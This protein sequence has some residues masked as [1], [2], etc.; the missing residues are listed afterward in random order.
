MV[1]R[2]VASMAAVG[3]LVIGA[4]V[5]A[6]P[7]SA[8]PPTDPWQ[9]TASADI[10]ELNVAALTFDF[11]G[12][13]V[14]ASDV[15]AGSTLDPRA[16]SASSN[17]G[18]AVLGVPIAVSTND[19]TAPP[20]EGPLT[21]GLAEVDVPT[22][23][24]TGLITT[25]N[26][27]S[28]TVDTAC[29]T[30]GVLASAATSV[31]GIS[32]LPGLAGGIASIG[33]AEVTSQTSLVP[34][35]IPNYNVQSTAVGTVAG[36]SLLGG[37]VE[38]AVAGNT[39]LTATSTAT[40]DI[41]IGYDP[42]TVTVSALGTDV[43]LTPA[44]PSRTVSIGLPLVGT[45]SVTVGL[46]S[47]TPIPGGAAVSLLTISI[48]IVSLVSLPV[49]TV[50]LDLVPL[51]ASVSAPLGGIDCPPPP[52]TVTAP[53]EG[54][55]TGPAPTFAG[56]ALP[57]ATVEVFVDGASIGTTTAD[58]AG[59][60]TLAAPTPLA[61]GPHVVTA[62]Q[63]VAGQV[64]EPSVA[65]DFVVDATPPPAPAISAPTDGA[66]LDDATPDI[67][68]TAEA[69]STVTVTIDGVVAGTAT[70]DAA[71]TWTFTPS[72]P[73]TD[74][75]HT[76]TATATDAAG[77]E[78][79][80]SNAVDFTI[81]SVAPEA[82]V[83]TSPA[84]GAVTNDTTPDITGTAEPNSTVTVTIDGVVA[85]TATADAAGTWTF[86]P[87]TPLTEGPHTVTA[88]ATDAAGNVSDASAPVTF[89]VDATPP[90]APVIVTPAEGQVTTDTTPDITG[91]AEPD[92]TIT[93]T[94]DGAIAGTTAADGTGNWVFTPTTPLAEGPHTVSATATDAAGNESPTS[95]LVNFTIDSVAPE[96]PVITSPANG[97]VTN[98]TTPDITGTA[99]PNST[100]T[101]TIDGVVAGTATADAAGTWTFTPTT[102]LTEGPHTVTA[103]ATDAAGN[104]SDASAPVE[105]TVDTVA[106]GTPVITGPTDGALLTDTTPDITGTAEP[107]STVTVTIDG[108]VAGTT[109]ADAAGSWTFTPS[110]PLGEGPHTVTAT[111]TDAAGNESPQSSAV[112][113]TID[114]VPP[115]APVI[116]GP[117][118]GD[119]LTD[120]T[121][122]ITGTAEPNSTVTVTIDGVVVG[123]TTADATGTW[124]FTPS[125]P[126]TEGPHTVTATAT[127]A[128]GNEGP[129]SAPVEFTVDTVPPAAPVITSP[130]D[131]STTADQAPEIS[132]IAE[133]GSTVTVIIDGEAAGQ[134]TADANG[135]WTFTPTQP[136]A[137]GEHEITAT[138]T[139][140]AGNTSPE[141][142]PTVVTVEAAPI[143]GVPE[144]RITMSPATQT[145]APGSRVEFTV[146][147][148]NAGD[149]AATNIVTRL[150]T[151]TGFTGYSGTAIAWPTGTP[152]PPDGVVGSLTFTLAELAP[153]DTVV[154]E[155]TGTANG[156]PGTALTITGAV[157][158]AEIDPL[159]A[160][161]IA[162]T[163]IA[164]AST[165][166]LPVTGGG[167]PAAALVPA[168]M[169][170]ALGVSLMVLG[171]RRAAAAHRR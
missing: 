148:R 1:R 113:F 94:I 76:V 48:D 10:V 144:V 105:F 107:S 19:A 21:G 37:A 130:T 43:V 171:R 8:A 84:N 168:G 65:V 36:V 55:T 44:A 90:P 116:T 165:P 16:Q 91:A 98:D 47:P 87:T 153:G 141:A 23:I 26:S 53:T 137:D 166:G 5:V 73:L 151:P 101:V 34:S 52:P 20:S 106:P 4:V 18:A 145:V 12:L 68:G 54:E 27:A 126:L 100:V 128:A 61:G 122:E 49:A 71:G 82:P 22:L 9:G 112:T 134:T 7:A 35:A 33:A 28:W 24:D 143:A 92:T 124:T 75:P 162:Q 118:T 80:P 95:N 119:L 70:A 93:V 6:P 81:D 40:S 127:D 156:S 89:T 163:V 56:T 88:T 158:M 64:S 133:P 129:A 15:S 170:L 149:A 30:D 99:E 104:E 77:N 42:A 46:N 109:T 157:T 102:P 31:A 78:S 86:T 38:V 135:E 83:I 17:I 161:N 72:S 39:T 103:T 66:L 97:A 108:V 96:A 79:P 85:G 131:G 142:Q 159:P 147:V 2:G 69:N 152:Q 62:T 13:S 14:G 160:N 125:S 167:D 115:G 74:G 154:Y 45:A 111:A 11:V 51:T 155:V 164:F 120:A 132:G 123:T 60:W 58:A 117:A 136:L 25:T 140:N 139:D 63:T 146:T 32:L 59:D 114:S 138:A 121:P 57:N 29:V 150:E 67:T 41:Q 3:A 50:S 169:L 110:S